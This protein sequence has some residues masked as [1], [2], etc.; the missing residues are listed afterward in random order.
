MKTFVITGA[1]SGIGLAVA[2]NLVDR[3][4]HVI[5]V[6][7][8]PQRCHSCEQ[9]LGATNK[10]VSVKYLL[11]DLS[12]QSSVQSLAG[13]IEQHLQSIAASGLD[14]L[15]NN[16]AT[17]PFWETLTPDGIDLQWAV[18]YLSG[19]LLTHLLSPVLNAASAG[20]IVSVSSGSHYHTRLDMRD[21]PVF[22]AYNPLSAYKRTKLAQVL[23]TEAFNRKM[24]ARGTVRA[25]AADPGLVKTDIGLKSR[26]RFMR[27]IWQIRRG[28]GISS[29][30]AARGIVFL[31]LDPHIQYDQASYWKHGK[32][33]KP[34]HVVADCGLSDL[35]WDR[36]AMLCGIEGITK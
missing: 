10:G 8:D 7:R 25:F 28:K 16:A 4:H 21:F 34:N 3:G 33:K 20:R 9:E 12:E 36:S 6:G 27:L 22:R 32:S 11:A 15:V 13:D 31:L 23:F 17:V 1:T 2:R 29:L 35:L 24:A 14:G 19:F 30:E 18:N 26:S 5:G